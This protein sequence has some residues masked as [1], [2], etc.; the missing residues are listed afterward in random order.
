M[1]GPHFAVYMHL[2]QV[3][4]LIALR[5]GGSIIERNL[6]II[7]DNLE[8]VREFI[9]A[10]SDKFEWQEPAAGSVAFPRLKTGQPVEEFCQLVR[11]GCGVLLLPATVYDH[12]EVSRKGHF[13][14]GLGRQDLA[15][16]LQ[17]LDDFL[18]A[19]L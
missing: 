1:P 5:N 17:Q 18:E 15:V 11:E 7:S 3:L 12:E 2:L 13:R 19:K 6:E 14:I 8:L 4:A 9:S 16:C 10:R